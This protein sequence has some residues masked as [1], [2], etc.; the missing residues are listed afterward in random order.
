MGRRAVLTVVFLLAMPGVGG[1]ESPLPA[2]DRCDEDVR[3]R[4][5]ELASYECYWR[6][7]RRL[8]AW[9]EAVR[10]L[11]ALLEYDPGNPRAEL[12]LG[13]IE[14]DRNHDRAENLYRDAIE[15]FAASGDRQGE[16]LARVSLGMFLG[17]RA[18]HD[19][20]ALQL[21]AAEIA[22]ADSGEPLLLA[23][24]STRRGWQ[25]YH[26]ND[27]GRAWIFFRRAREA[28]FP[29]GP[30]DLRAQILDG[31]AATAWAKGSYR[32]GLDLY[33]AEAEIVRGIG[34]LRWE[35]D[36]L[37][38]VALLATEPEPMRS[39]G[40][41]EVRGLA[42]QA[43]DV[44]VQSGNRRAE[45]S[46]RRQ[47]ARTLRLPG[48]RVQELE[49][50]LRLAR[51]TGERKGV[52][53]ALAEL[54]LALAREERGRTGRVRRLTDEA[55]ALA[56]AGAAPAV[57]AQ[58]LVVR[59]EI[60]AGFGSREEAIASGLAALDAIERIRVLQPDRSVRM[61]TFS[62][63]TPAYYKLAHYVLRQ[64][65]RDAAPAS[66]L[67][68]GIV[69]R[70]RARV[71][72]DT[73][74]EAGASDPGDGGAPLRSQWSRK[75]E[76]IAAVQRRLLDSRLDETGRRDALAMLD[77][78]ELEERALRDTVARADPAFA[79]IHAPSLPRFSD[80]R[81]ALAPDEALLSFQ[82]EPGPV[83][84]FDEWAIRPW[85]IAVTRDHVAAYE[86]APESELKLAVH[87]FLGLVER[88]DLTVARGAAALFEKVFET[89]IEELPDEV[90]R[91]VLV[92]DG[93]L[94]SVPFGAL[95][96]DPDSPPL[97]ARYHIR[98]VPS[99]ALWLLWN[100]RSPS[101]PEKG[102]LALADP[103]LPSV[104]D[105]DAGRRAAGAFAEFLGL[106]ALPLARRE[107]REVIGGFANE[108]LLLEGADASERRLK[109][110]IAAGYR[111]LHVAAHAVLDGRHPSRS[112]LVLS[113]G[114]ET[115]DGLLQVREIVDLELD[116][117]V[118]FLSACSS[119]SGPVVS[120]EGVVGFA[121][122]FLQ[123]GARAVV[124]SLWP[125]RDDEAAELAGDLSRRLAGGAGLGEALAATRRDWIAEGRPEAAWAG[126]VLI[127]N[128]DRVLE[129]AP[130]RRR[131]PAG[132]LLAALGIAAL[133]VATG[134]TLRHR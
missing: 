44:A 20:A 47:L 41:E 102:V 115:E 31:L 131:P 122:A 62:R 5:D 128:D 49:Q 108:S 53:E 28:A 3:D 70:M 60:D 37:A 42:Q 77:T 43:V 91:L 86:L 82:V 61:E 80:V 51:E 134:L 46:A 65:S 76:E 107:A 68:L 94:H 12:Y 129:E 71:L 74:D 15:A 89:A 112:A 32:H 50:A 19:E 114:G 16:V 22:A 87:M 100:R 29:E 30:P 105:D 6:T 90:D 83:D 26:G 123:A 119:A 120:G 25:A 39:I 66:D 36:I 111:L 81:E 103:E 10:R 73:L 72:L 97:A 84:A 54:A 96:T 4:P 57:L 92:P 56:R 34:D 93:V 75:Q 9:P 85:L 110:E 133:L 69:E 23:R 106:G 11:E 38:N 24:T 63:W 109:T 8:R 67:A 101:L 35:A 113:P 88:R 117:T 124:G 18:R 58:V 118:V 7:A 98:R 33:L 127:G 45:S 64:A 13:A 55:V 2:F 52:C 21:E 59:A 17:Y 130:V 1:V 116:G 104:N 14:A 121:R 95:R 78:L 48:R 40:I 125:L 132:V 27:F 79:R 99:V 126:T